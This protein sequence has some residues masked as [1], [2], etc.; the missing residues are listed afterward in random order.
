MKNVTVEDC[1]MCHRRFCS[2]HISWSDDLRMWICDKDLREHLG[3][4]R[5]PALPRALGASA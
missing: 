3:Y 5:G 4:K 2:E 1:G